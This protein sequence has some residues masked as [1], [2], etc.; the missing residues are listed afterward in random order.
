MQEPSPIADTAAM[1]ADPSRATMLMALMDGR[2]YTAS[3]LSRAAGIAPSTA[4]FHLDKLRTTGYLESIRQGRHHYFRLAGRHVARAIESLMTVSDAL[5]PGDIPSRCPQALRGA[6]VCY[7]H[8][9]GRLG[10][11]VHEAMQRQGWLAWSEQTWRPTAEASEFLAALGIEPDSTLH[12]RP[13][14]DWS[15]RYFHLGGPLAR[16]LLDG[17]LEKRWILRGEGRALVATADGARRLNQWLGDT[18]PAT[19]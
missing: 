6:R 13:C 7:D 1:L 10:V 15:E 5:R 4:S 18:A 17:M 8:L 2:A 16:A 3:E 9:A 12:G 19:T 11:R 14:L